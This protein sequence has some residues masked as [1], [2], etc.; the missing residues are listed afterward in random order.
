MSE[1][2]KYQKRLLNYFW[3]QGVPYSESQDLVQ[4]TYLRLWKYRDEYQRLA[5]M[6]TFLFLL[7]RQ[8]RIDALRSGIRRLRREEKWAK[9]R[10]TSVDPATAEHEDI[11][12]ALKK[13]TPPLREAVELVVFQDMSYVEAAALLG[14][15]I[16]TLK[17]RMSNALRKLKEAFNEQGS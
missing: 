8:V 1:A 4:E 2:K 6:T 11:R 10:L 13:L 17:S 5:R 14:I 3:R 16:G 9:E 7:A 15:P 12:W